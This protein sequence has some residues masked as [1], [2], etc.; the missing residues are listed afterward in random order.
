M[1]RTPPSTPVGASYS[2]KR[3]S[4]LPSIP[5]TPV[6]V[7]VAAFYSGKRKSH[8]PSIITSPAPLSAFTI[9]HGHDMFD[10]PRFEEFIGLSRPELNFVLQNRLPA[11][12]EG[13]KSMLLE[14]RQKITDV[15]AEED[16]LRAQRDAHALAI[17]SIDSQLS[18]KDIQKKHYRENVADIQQ[19]LE[20]ADQN[21]QIV[22][23]AMWYSKE[24]SYAVW[25]ISR[26]QMDMKLTEPADAR[27]L[28]HH[29]GRRALY[30][31]INMGF[32]ENEACPE[33]KV[34]TFNVSLEELHDRIIFLLGLAHATAVG[35]GGSHDDDDDDEALE[36]RLRDQLKDIEERRAAKKAR[37]Y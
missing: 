7:A 10:T 4:R 27:K 25:P 2:G 30:K 12:Q 21:L 17:A 35:D 16:E 24:K 18:D 20:D 31:L 37:H 28:D 14:Y 15:T 36:A 8:L 22:R 23:W 5:S 26:I 13:Y 34:P 3:K 19:G 11:E 1:F 6:G 29:D 9:R 33:G 32:E